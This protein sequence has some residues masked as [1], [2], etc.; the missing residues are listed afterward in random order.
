MERIRIRI[1]VALLCIAILFLSSII[2]P[3][4]FLDWGIVP[5]VI[6]TPDGFI[7]MKTAVPET[8]HDV[9]IYEGTIWNESPHYLN[10]G[11]SGPDPISA[12]AAPS[13]AQSVLERCCGGVPP[14]A[15]PPVSSTDFGGIIKT[16]TGEV[17]KKIPEETDVLYYRKINGC[18][19]IGNGN[20]IA[21]VFK[22][23]G[24]VTIYE[25]WSSLRNSGKNAT[26]IT[27]AQALKKMSV[28]G[29]PNLPMG[30]RFGVVIE[31]VSLGYYGQVSS[32]DNIE[33]I[34]VWIFQEKMF[35]GDSWEMAVS[36]QEEPSGTINV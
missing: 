27:P 15:E 9:G 20:Q 33:F 28:E 1:L 29:I 21:V 18:P 32:G 36:A 4:I 35:S 25:R 16:D 19:V 30:F 23:E 5:P 17:L 3:G 13:V 26:L 14:D 6:H 11:T 10:L 24:A 34:P 8:P 31:N 22:G 7:M 2:L 12:E